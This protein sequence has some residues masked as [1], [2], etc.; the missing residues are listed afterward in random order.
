VRAMQNFILQEN[1]KI[2]KKK[3][4]KIHSHL[5]IH[6]S[7]STQLMMSAIACID[8]ALCILYAVFVFIVFCG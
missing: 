5:R 8:D 4:K 7:P 1:H 6:P 3:L 2:E